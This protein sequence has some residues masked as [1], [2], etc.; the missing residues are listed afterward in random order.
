MQ[1]PGEFSPFIEKKVFFCL[2]VG[3]GLPLPTPIV[4]RPLKKQLF[5]C[6]SSLSGPTTKGRPPHLYL[7]HLP[8]SGDTI[9]FSLLFLK[10]K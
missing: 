9:F 3:G 6:V 10:A 5:L 7:T 8:R 4:V 2:V 1:L